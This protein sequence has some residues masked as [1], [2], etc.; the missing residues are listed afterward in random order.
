MTTP[1]DNL[2]ATFFLD[3]L[4]QYH[5]SLLGAERVA[6]SFAAAEPESVTMYVERR[7]QE[8]LADGYLPDGSFWHDELRKL[9]PAFALARQ[10]AGVEHE[11][12]RL[13][14]EL[15]RVQGLF[16]AFLSLFAEIRVWRP[17]QTHSSVACAD[18]NFAA[19]RGWI[20]CRNSESI[21]DRANSKP[22]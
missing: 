1:Y 14:R 21:A 15:E 6:R 10:W 4:G 13:H 17:G 2:D 18:A 11:L 12:Q 19:I 8:L 3:R 5:T 22:S 9:R 7:E 16:S 20:V